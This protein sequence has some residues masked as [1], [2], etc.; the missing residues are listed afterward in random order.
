MK[1]PDRSHLVRIGANYAQLGGS[2]LIGLF[3]VRILLGLGESVYGVVALLIAGSSLARLLREVLQVG[4]VPKLGA[5]WNAEDGEN[6][7]FSRMYSASI[8]VAAGCAG[9]TLIGFGILDQALGWFDIP[10]SLREAASVFVWLRG[11]QSA[12]AIL[13]GP[14]LTMLLVR[15][16]FVTHNAIVLAERA[17][18]LVA[19]IVTLIVVGSDDPARAITTYALIVCV[20]SIL[21]HAGTAFML[22]MRNRSMRPRFG[23]ASRRDTH[24]V[25]ASLGWNAIHAIAMNLHLRLDVMIMNG[26]FGLIPGMLFSIA[27]QAA[28]YV[29]QR[30]MGLVGGVDALSARHRRSENAEDLRSLLQNQMAM[31]ASVILPAAG[32]LIIGAEK[33]IGLWLHGRLENPAESIPEVAFYCRILI[34]GVV[35]RS[36]SESWI[37]ALTG[38]GNARKFAPLVLAGALLNPVLIFAGIALVSKPADRLVPAIC[39]SAIFVIVH[40]VLIPR[41]TAQTLGIA[42]AD[43][44]RPAKSPAIAVAPAGFA[45]LILSALEIGSVLPACAFLVVYLCCLRWLGR[46]WIAE[47]NE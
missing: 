34:I 3:V 13:A 29:R 36:F 8:L 47:K 39:F 2:F 17:L 24:A 19:A 45:A 37:S 43:L 28:S 14:T 5:A 9:L 41:V 30:T 10:E 27:G 38:T 12:A 42:M 44:F 40:L 26:V 16:K 4:L 32:F 6:D 15:E 21:L 18:D 7:E 23:R 20:G 33:L 22:V 46:D 1:I 25:I 11:L 35:A 31:Q